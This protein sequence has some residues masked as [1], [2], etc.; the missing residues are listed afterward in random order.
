MVVL[1]TT[2]GLQGEK[3]LG[4]W[5]NVEKGTQQNRFVTP[6]EKDWL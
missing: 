4:R 2:S 1:I 6:Q 5:N 3:P